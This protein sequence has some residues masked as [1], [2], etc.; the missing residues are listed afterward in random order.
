[1]GEDLLKPP[2]SD[3]SQQER[4]RINSVTE[5]SLVKRPGE[6]LAGETHRSGIGGD[7]PHS[8]G[9]GMDI[10]TGTQKELR[11][12]LPEE[13]LLVERQAVRHD[14]TGREGEQSPELS[15]L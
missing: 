4:E 6:D 14:L 1:M 11:E 10:G 8:E 5:D 7:P 3:L 15:A 2:V 12:R 13:A 9:S